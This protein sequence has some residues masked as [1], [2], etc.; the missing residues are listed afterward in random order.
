MDGLQQLLIVFAGLLLFNAILSGVLWARHRTPL[1]RALF[2]VWG[3]GIVSMI[4]QGAVQS[5]RWMGFVFGLCNVGMNL[6]LVELVGGALRLRRRPRLHLTAFA[7]GLVGSAAATMA[8]APFWL[9][10]LPITLGSTVPLADLVVQAVRLPR[11]RLSTTGWASVFATSVMAIHML[12]YPFLRDDPGFAPLGFVIAILAVFAVSVTAPAIVLEHA[13]LEVERL[14]AALEARVAEAT[15]AVRARDEFVAIAA[16]EIRGPLNALHLAV[17]TLRLGA[18][19]LPHARLFDVVERSDRRLA[20]F[21]DQLLDLGRA[22]SGA[23]HLEL[24]PVDLAEVVRTVARQ[25]DAELAR[26]G[27]ALTIACDPAVVGTWDRFRLGQ[28]VDNLLSN[29]IKFGLGRPIEVAATTQ[30]ADAR[31]LV[32]DRGPGIP[33]ELGERIFD[34]FERGVATRNH[35]GLGLGLHIVREIVTALG[36]TIRVDSADGAGARFEVT[37]PTA[38]PAAEAA[39]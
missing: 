32:I 35:G 8:G 29:A 22:R 20:R 15:A 14:N 34:P 19:E 16:H 11:G 9:R 5:D 6:L 12:D 27:S 28:V 1:H 24:E 39:R 37:L 36:G 7:V 2:G 38:S 10:T 17:Q 31:L 25:L 4:A 13:S 26:S 21:V 33:R 23:L 3:M 18:D 30:G